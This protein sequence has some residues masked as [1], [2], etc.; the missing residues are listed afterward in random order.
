[1]GKVTATY[2]GH[3]SVMFGQR[4][5]ERSQNNTKVE[6]LC[7]YKQI[8]WTPWAKGWRFKVGDL[9]VADRRMTSTAIHID[10]R[11]ER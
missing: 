11:S 8:Q 6:N 2:E 1:M 4:R 3:I 10:E 5:W 9:M 7:S